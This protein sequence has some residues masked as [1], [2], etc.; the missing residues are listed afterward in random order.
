MSDNKDFSD[1]DSYIGLSLVFLPSLLSH[2][3]SVHVTGVCLCR[4]AMLD[5]S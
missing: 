5:L 4:R 3:I 2:D 1:G